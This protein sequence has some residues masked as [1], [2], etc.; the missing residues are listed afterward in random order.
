MKFQA[1]LALGV[2]TIFWGT[3]NRAA[4]GP[5]TY[6]L[7]TDW[8][9]AHNPN[10]VWSY[11]Q[12]TSP[13]TIHQSNWNTLDFSSPQPAWAAAQAQLPN[14]VPAWLKS[15]GVASSPSLDAPKGRV[16]VHGTSPNSST[17]Q[18]P[19]DVSWT[20]PLDGTIVITGDTWLARKIYGRAMDWNIYDNGTLLTH[21]SLT[22]SDPFTSAHPF[23]FAS[24]TGGPSVLT[25]HVSVGEVITFE[26]HWTAVDAEFVGV[27][28]TITATATEVPEPGSLI[29]LLVGGTVC[30]PLWG[31]KK[32]KRK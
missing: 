12:G 2:L 28:L 22:S 13:I 18:A 26:T 11:N 23:L 24:G 6:D 7:A 4:A 10:G 5:I 15:L 16:L 25:R 3:L 20:S 14:H 8:S 27:D 19:A 17:N 31:L 30:A 1:L 21:G 32:R 29:L 9:D